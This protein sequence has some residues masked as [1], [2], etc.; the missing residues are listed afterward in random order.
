MFKTVKPICVYMKYRQCFELL[1]ERW[2]MASDRLCFTPST[3][4][5]STQLYAPWLF[6][7][8]PKNL[9]G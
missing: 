9:T 3:T 5:K 7:I 8:T 4:A 1:T 6:W 2:R